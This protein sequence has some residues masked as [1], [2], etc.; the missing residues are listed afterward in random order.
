MI[1]KTIIVG[2]L[3]LT[4]VVGSMMTGDMDALF[5]TDIF[6]QFNTKN[7]SNQSH[8]TEP[9]QYLTSGVPVTLMID[10][11]TTQVKSIST[12]VNPE[13][14][15]SKTTQV[16]PV[17]TLVNPESI[18]S[19]TITPIMKST[20]EA[21]ADSTLTLTEWN[22]GISIR[23]ASLDSSGNIYMTGSGGSC[24]YC[25]VQIIPST[26]MLTTWA[27]IAP[28]SSFTGVATH[29]SDVFFTD[30]ANKIGKLDP[31]TNT[32]TEWAIPTL[33]SIPRSIEVDS[34][35]NVFFTQSDPNMIGRLVPSTN[36]FTE[37]TL[38]ANGTP[39]RLTFDHFDNIFFTE[40]G[41][42]GRLVPSTGTFTEW[43]LLSETNPMGIVVDASGNVFIA[44]RS[45]SRIGMLVPSETLSTFTEYYLPAFATPIDMMIDSSGKIFFTEDNGIPSKIGRLG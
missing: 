40:Q 28:G 32:V 36:T 10:A 23:N 18:G 17:S 21:L 44:E 29:G 20:F 27:V 38:P 6:L 24:S 22:S 31:S 39:Y 11:K 4:F 43:T 9:P 3:T 45:Y 16:K 33:N 35:G 7:E 42:I 15:G 25:L 34:S 14:I 37:W 13:S 1:N 30:A 26:N 5:G 41:K 19:K 12:L 8:N 2:L